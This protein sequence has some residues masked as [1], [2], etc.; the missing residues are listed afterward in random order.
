MYCGSGERSDVGRVIAKGRSS[1]K[2]AEDAVERI[3]PISQ[4]L[5]DS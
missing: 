4:G 5:Y 3:D 1:Q 2:S